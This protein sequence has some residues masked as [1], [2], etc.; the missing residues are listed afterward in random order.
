MFFGERVVSEGF[1]GERICM[2][3]FW[4]GKAEGTQILLRAQF[5]LR[6]NHTLTLRGSSSS[7]RVSK[8]ATALL[9]VK[10]A[11][12]MQQHNSIRVGK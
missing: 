2:R 3:D 1:L 5:W 9:P 11:G 4:G 12:A 6:G 10:K 8:Y 7:T